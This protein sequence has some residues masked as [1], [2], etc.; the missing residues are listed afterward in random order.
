MFLYLRPETNGIKV[1]S[2]IMRT[3]QQRLQYKDR[4]KLAYLAN[5]P[6]DFIAK[7]RI[8]EDHYSLKLHFTKTGKQ[9]FTPYMKKE[10]SRYFG[11]SFDKAK[12]YGAFEAMKRLGYTREGLF[13][14][15]VP[16]RDVF[17]VNGQTIKRDGDIFIINYDI[18]AILNK[19][20]SATDVAVMIL[21][22]SFEPKALQRMI[23]DM[24][25]ELRKEEV[26]DKTKGYSRVFHYSKGPFEQLLDAVGFLYDSQG[27][28]LSP[29]KMLFFNYLLEKGLHTHEVSKILKNPIFLFQGQ[30]DGQKQFEETIYT[31]TYEQSYEEAYNTLLSAKAQVIL[32]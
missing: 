19:N 22:T 12:I 7:N 30:G 13:N 23:M 6:G 8:I 1:E 32:E 5:I 17:H 16:Q 29:D 9:L 3:L 26:I 28:H 4:V 20:N 21:R 14:L 10:F 24:V 18:P 25:E 11:V 2:V 27:N 31:A 15:W